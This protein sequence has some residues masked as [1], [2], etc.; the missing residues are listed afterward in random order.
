M[1]DAQCSTLRGRN[2]EHGASA[3]AGLNTSPDL[4]G[5][6]AAPKG[7]GKESEALGEVL[8]LLILPGCRVRGDEQRR[9]G[10]R[11]QGSCAAWVI[12]IS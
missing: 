6:P 2:L 4:D 7:L 5:A 1:C 3:L 11:T 8:S 12:K 9:V 10:P